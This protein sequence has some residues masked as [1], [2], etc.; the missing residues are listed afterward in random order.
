MSDCNRSDLKTNVNTIKYPFLQFH[1]GLYC[2]IFLNLN[3]CYGFQKSLGGIP[4]GGIPLGGT[5]L[6]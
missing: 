3:E 5:P 2:V 4:L 1:C 6:I